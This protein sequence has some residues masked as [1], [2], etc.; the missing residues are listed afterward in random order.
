M[1]RCVPIF[2]QVH[3]SV[4]FNFRQAREDPVAGWFRAAAAMDCLRC[5]ERSRTIP[6]EHWIREV[7]FFDGMM[8]LRLH[9]G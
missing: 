4:C 6:S 3:T 2:R 1:R 5:A 7:C 9:T 8:G